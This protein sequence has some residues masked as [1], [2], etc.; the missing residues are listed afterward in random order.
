M[1]TITDSQ[2]FQYATELRNLLISYEKA[3]Q[4]ISTLD[5]YIQHLTQQTFW[6]TLQD[7]TPLAIRHLTKKSIASGIKKVYQ[8]VS[9]Q[10]WK[11]VTELSVLV[12][13]QLDSP[14]VQPEPPTTSAGRS[15]EMDEMA[16]LTSQSFCELYRSA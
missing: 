8:Q 4:Q 9:T 15:T 7:S 16:P 2:L 12:L 14:D 11:R 10:K 13:Q 1:A 6:S 3:N 5:S